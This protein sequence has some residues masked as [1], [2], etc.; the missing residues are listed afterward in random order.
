MAIIQFKPGFDAAA[1]LRTK[2]KGRNLK[3]VASHFESSKRPPINLNSKPEL[4]KKRNDEEIP[5]IVKAFPGRL[6]G[7]SETP[8]N[9]QEFVNQQY[10]PEN[11]DGNR[12]RSKFLISLRHT[13][14][15]QMNMA[16][17]RTR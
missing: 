4:A 12:Y 1:Y 6:R 11:E 3:G 9:Q 16:P 2:E 13:N 8:T 14:R 15:T 7:Q 5:P 17:T 10:P